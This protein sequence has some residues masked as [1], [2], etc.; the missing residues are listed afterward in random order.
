MTDLDRLPAP[1]QPPL[2][3]PAHPGNRP[4]SLSGSGWVLLVM[5][6]GASIAAQL[7][8]YFL[9]LLVFS[10]CGT[11]TGYQESWAMGRILTIA[12]VVATAGAWWLAAHI[13]RYRDAIV[14]GGLVSTVF[15]IF[16]V[17]HAFNTDMWAQGWCF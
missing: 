15:G 10:T 11:N 9:V 3:H 2:G 7:V 1:D 17:V 4:P 5:A 13:G 6:V 14:G 16:V 8:G 12:G